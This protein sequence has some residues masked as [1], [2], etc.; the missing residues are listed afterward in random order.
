MRRAYQEYSNSRKTPCDY[1]QKNILPRRDS[2]HDDKLRQFKEGR[3]AYWPI[4]R[5]EGIQRRGAAYL[6]TSVRL[7]RSALRLNTAVGQRIVP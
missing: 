4:S 5:A 6:E 3:R 1:Y 2:I 7:R